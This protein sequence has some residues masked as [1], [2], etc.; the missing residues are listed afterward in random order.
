MKIPVSEVRSD[1][2]ENLIGSLVVAGNMDI[3]EVCLYF[4]NRLLRGNRVQK[5]DNNGLDAFGSPNMAPIADMEIDVNVHYESIFRS[6]SLAAFTV[7]ENLCRNVVVLRIFPSISIESVRAFL[8]P[9]TQGIII[10]KAVL[11]E[12]KETSTM[13][14]WQAS[15]LHSRV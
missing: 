11:A 12:R 3:P 8:R 10:Y 2:R 4:N 1:G 5:L 9:P 14:K 7:H 13:A 15:Q 6:G